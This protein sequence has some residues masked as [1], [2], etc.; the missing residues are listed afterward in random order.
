MSEPPAIRLEPFKP[1]EAAFD[2]FACG[3]CHKIAGE[4]GD[5]GPNLTHIGALREKE[6]LRRA[7]LDPNADIAKGFKPDAMPADYG[8]QMYAI[9]LEMTVNYLAE[10]K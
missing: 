9:E 8:E 3:A 7:L 4:E 2:E 1:A 6:Y 10:Q 5:I